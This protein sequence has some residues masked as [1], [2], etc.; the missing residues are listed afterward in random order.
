MVAAI[1]HLRVET[2]NRWPLLFGLPD[3]LGCPFT[4]HMVSTE[5]HLWARH[6]FLLYCSM[7]FILLFKIFIEVSKPITHSKIGHCHCNRTLKSNNFL[8]VSVD[9]DKCDYCYVHTSSMSI[10]WIALKI[11]LFTGLKGL[12]CLSYFSLLWAWVWLL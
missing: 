6:P 12:G 1:Q 4:I 11:L 10:H 5:E 8:W 9:G 3:Y 2:V 7:K